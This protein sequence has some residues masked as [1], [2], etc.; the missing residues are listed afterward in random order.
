MPPSPS[1]NDRSTTGREVISLGHCCIAYGRQQCLA[2][3][4]C[5]KILVESYLSQSSAFSGSLLSKRIR[6]PLG[7]SSRSS[8]RHIA[9]M[10]TTP[11]RVGCL[12]GQIVAFLEAVAQIQTL[13]IATSP[14]TPAQLQG[15]KKST[16]RHPGSALSASLPL[17]DGWVGSTVWERLS[18]W[19][20]PS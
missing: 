16:G 1:E 13:S 19:V 8:P 9:R 11:R 6:S 3:N 4:R 17:G 14:V 18:K 12:I 5:L 7:C 10:L 2:L 15:T 20:G